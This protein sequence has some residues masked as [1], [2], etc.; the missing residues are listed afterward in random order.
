MQFRSVKNLLKP[1][2]KSGHEWQNISINGKEQKPRLFLSDIQWILLLFSILSNFLLKKGLS[3]S[4]IGY[5]ISAF[6]ISVSLF[7]SLLISIFDKFEKTEFSTINKTEVEILRLIQKKNFFKRFISITS[8][9]VVLS[10]LVIIISSLTY[11]FNLAKRE[12]DINLLTI[13]YEKIDVILT[14]KYIFL[15][16]YRTALNYFLLSY[17]LLTLFIS[18]SAFEFYMSEINNKKIL[19]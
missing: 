14:I 2:I 13:E 17:L 9:L 10:I 7:M 16:L 3:E 8:Y 6:S 11:I 12:L 4:I 5:V 1:L 19:E 15:A 18:G